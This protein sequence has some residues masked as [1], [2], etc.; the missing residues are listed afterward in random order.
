VVRLVGLM[1]LLPALAL[2]T[3]WPVA[4]HA[5]ELPAV[6]QSVSGEIVIL[7]KR[8]PLP[9][10]P[11]RVA[12]VGFGQ[13]M[14]E[15]P[16]PY[17]AIGGALL[18]RPDN[19]AQEFLLIHTNA[20]PVRNGWGAPSECSTDT[21]LFRSAAETRNQHNGCSFLLATRV[22]WL[23]R[24]QLPALRDEP[25][26]LAQL[27]PW[28]VLAGL[29]VSDRRDVLDIRYGIMP[30]GLAAADWFGGKEKL[31]P[32]HRA[33]VN[34]IAEWA[35]QARVSALAALRDPPD[36]VPPMPALNSSSWLDSSGP[37]GEEISSITL[38][39]YKLATYRIPASMATFAIGW[40][41]SGNIYTGLQMMLWQGLT[42]SAVFF[43]NELAWE[44]PDATRPMRF[45]AVPAPASPAVPDQARTGAPRLQLAAVGPEL[46]LPTSLRPTPSATTFPFVGKQVPLP[47]TGWMTLAS[48][49][50]DGVT[51]T[52][53]ARIKRKA[54]IGLAVARTNERKL[55]AIFGTTW[56][57]ARSDIYFAAVRYDTPED[58]YCLYAKQ[59]VPNVAAGGNALWDKA[60]A[61]LQADGVALPRSLMMVGARARTRENL[62]DVRYYFAAP[63]ALTSRDRDDTGLTADP[64]AALQSWADLMQEPIELGV[65]GRIPAAELQAPWPW[66]ADATTT[67]LVEQTHAPL[68]ALAAAGALDE[69]TLRS[70]LVL[71]D[72]AL[73]DRERQRWSLWSRSA[74]KVA[75]YRSASY[76]DSVA[77]SWLI[78][79][80]VGQS[81]AFAT[82]N[83]LARPVMAYVNEIGW[84][85]SGMG[86]APA[87]LLPVEFPEIGPEFR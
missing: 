21:T 56:E 37:G 39:L 80:S 81:M 33:L 18:V 53:L 79:G 45:I 5:T 40:G 55:D 47:G 25:A 67:A 68:L 84:A 57:C 9:P 8:I 27:P 86:K 26:V 51:A 3:V 13:V 59:V 17:G 29:R 32:P 34:H 2:A 66:D 36:Q 54:V 41:L 12:S 35:Q 85:H 10:G 73:T 87:T 78:T 44:W 43:G 69:P 48:D 19:T 6:G 14:D 1:L 74:Y 72:A 60:M 71:A 62:L 64:V 16:G 30:S 65:R 20:L 22:G 24:S 23:A 15:D 76:L 70:Q 46:P 52:V 83:G 28:A 11:W 7:E 49:S 75:T 82:I 50:T 4:S 58:G 77:V 61:R 31:P 42:H 38:G 63:P